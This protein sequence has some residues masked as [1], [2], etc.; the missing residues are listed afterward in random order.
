MASIITYM[1]PGS[2]LMNQLQEPSNPRDD[3]VFTS[4]AEIVTALTGHAITGS[5]IKAMDN[6]YGAKYVGFASAG[7]LVDTL[8]RLGVILTRRGSSTQSGLVALLRTFVAAGSPCLVTMPSQWNSA[9]SVRGYNPRTYTGYMHVGVACGLGS[10]M[11]RVM[12]PWQGFWQDGTDSYW[13]QRLLTGDIWVATR[14]PTPPVV[15]TPPAPSQGQG[16]P[17]LTAVQYQA[18]IAQAIKDLS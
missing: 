11:I 9:V 10:G 16:A 14:K 1:V 7:N 3:C 12:N 5:Q 2:R 13:A 4:C 17:L 18:K 8:N 15:Q 6:N